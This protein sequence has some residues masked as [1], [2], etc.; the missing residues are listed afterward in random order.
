MRGLVFTVIAVVLYL[1]LYA[2]RLFVVPIGLRD[3]LQWLPGIDHADVDFSS[4]VWALWLLLGVYVVRVGIFVR[5]FIVPSVAM[6][7]EE[8]NAPDQIEK[9]TNDHT[10]PVVAYVAFSCVAG[11][12]AGSLYGLPAWGSVLLV[13]GVMGLYLLKPLVKYFRTIFAKAYEYA[14][15]AAQM[16]G[17]ALSTVIIEIIAAIARLERWRSSGSPDDTTVFAEMERRWRERR[18]QWREQRAASTTGWQ[19]RSTVRG[20]RR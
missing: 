3:L 13:L 7:D 14:S 4:P 17:S 6:S 16:I 19:G 18:N 20:K 2:D 9:R 8:F 5:L 10:A 11:A 1:V 15:T 12:L